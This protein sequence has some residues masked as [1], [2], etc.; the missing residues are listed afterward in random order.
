MHVVDAAPRATAVVVLTTTWEEF[1]A[2]WASLL[3][4]VY[5][6]VRARPDLAPE[7]GPGPCGARRVQP[8]L[9]PAPVAKA[10]CPSGQ[11]L[12]SSVLRWKGSHR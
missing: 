2:V 5:A 12:D 7:R 4:E 9:V 1:P 3:D 11:G 10:G 6:V 8:G